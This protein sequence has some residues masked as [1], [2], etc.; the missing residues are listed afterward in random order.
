MG[1]VEEVKMSLKELTKLNR[2]LNRIELMVKKFAQ[3]RAYTTMLFP[4]MVSSGEIRLLK[5]ENGFYYYIILKREDFALEKPYKS[6]F[7]EIPYSLTASI[8]GTKNNEFFE[9]YRNKPFSEIEKSILDDLFQCDYKLEKYKGESRQ[10]SIEIPNDFQQKSESYRAF[11]DLNFSINKF[12]EEF[13]YTYDYDPLGG[14]ELKIRF[15][16]NINGLLLSIILR[17]DIGVGDYFS[18]TDDA[19]YTLRCSLSSYYLDSQN[20]LQCHYYDTIF[21]EKRKFKKLKNTF[22]KDLVL[23]DKDII[24]MVKKF[25]D[26]F[27]VEYQI[28]T[29]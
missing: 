20:I 5:M 24:K 10:G 12:S 7:E 16:K 9:L 14:T 4:P 28:G 11:K 27:D 18:F 21:Y 25:L 15:F 3:L 1:G 26:D 19:L 2:H 23:C 6:F 29:I 22:Y 8:K 17:P 13:D